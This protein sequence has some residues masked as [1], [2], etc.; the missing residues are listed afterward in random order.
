MAVPGRKLTELTEAAP[1]SREAQ[2]VEE[3][4]R[5]RQ[6]LS[7]TNS[8]LDA[9]LD[10]L[11][12][13]TRL[14]R[15]A[16]RSWLQRLRDRIGRVLTP[17]LGVLKQYE[18]QVPNIPTWYE[19]EQ[20]PDNP[21]II[22]IVTPSLNHAR[23]LGRTMQS[24]ISQRY[25]RLEYVIQDGGSTDDTADLI[26]YFADKLT[27]Y[28]SAPDK[29]Q[30]DAINRGF[31][32]TTGEIM[33]YLNSDDMLLPGTLA[34]VARY[35]VENPHVDAVYG[36]RLIVDEE[37]M[38]IGRWVMPPHEDAP[39][40]WADFIPQESLFWRRRV[41]DKAGGY[42]DASFRFAMDWDLIVRLIKEGARF[43]RIGRFLGS[44]RVHTKQKTSRQLT[45]LGF[46]EMDRIRV[47]CHGRSVSMTE[48]RAHLRP[49]MRRSVLYHRL[50]LLGL[51]RY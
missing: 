35:F 32:H 5:I 34:R 21:P 44:F 10:A 38:E 12:H 46:A 22:S 8:G 49:Y 17:K 16:N 47:R 51:A 45:G 27:H 4:G 29:G 42:L 19:S 41:W 11:E 40:A 7:E 15:S 13:Q 18:P 26:H 1:E 39:L 43:E 24:V 3:M 36:H 31:A 20:L 30:A 48:I 28:E 2:I 9:I 25:P 23:Y 50:Y 14:M 6:T 33:A 37:D